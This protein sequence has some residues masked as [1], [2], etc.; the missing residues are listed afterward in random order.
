M[1]HPN[2]QLMVDFYHLSLEKEDPAIL[3]SAKKNIKHIHIANP[4]GR[5]VPDDRR[6]VRLLEVLR[7]RSKK[8]GYKGGISVEGRTEDYD[9]EA[10]K[11]VAFLRGAATEGVKPPS[12]PTPGRVP[13]GR[14]RRR[15]AGH[16]DQHRARAAGRARPPPR[17][18]ARPAAK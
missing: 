9:T 8:A 18:H 7:R 16:P 17:A 2:F 11:A 4:D 10:P 5:A 6:R 14:R 13:R 3:V 15:Q 12:G 1:N